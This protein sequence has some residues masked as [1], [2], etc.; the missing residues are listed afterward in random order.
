MAIFSHSR[1]SSFEQCK[2]KY[3]YHYIDKVETDV[4]RTIETYMGDLVHQTLEKL[5][6][7][8]KFQK[9]NDLS[10]LVDFYNGLWEKNWQ[11]GILIVKEQYTSENYRLM[12]QKMIEDYYAHYHP[13][14]Q[15]KTIG[16]ETEDYYELND[17]LSIHVR[18]DR[19]SSPKE[20]VYEIHDYKTNSNM[21]TQE[22]ADN[23]RQLAVYAMGVKKLFADAKRI[24]LIWHMLAFDK[25]VVSERTD[26]ELD[27]LK[28]EIIEEIGQIQKENSFDPTKSALC[29]Y[30]EYQSM[31]PLWK[32][33]FD[34]K[35]EEVNKEVLDG[36]T[37]VENYVKLK[38]YEKKVQ[39]KLSVVSDKIKLYADENNCRVLYGDNNAVTIWSKDAT[40]FPGKNDENRENFK[41]ALKAL[42]LYDRFVDVDTWVLEKEFPNFS[43]VEKSV[44]NNFGRKEKIFRLYLKKR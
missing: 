24:K 8:L 36:K 29:S 16:L 13:F 39:E 44:L 1:I 31:C 2:L 14:N 43:E 37:L 34:Q 38:E 17:E 18:I 42:N 22:E 30:C 19:L 9:L 15:G 20:G 25:E 3:K 21:K 11:E 41:D 40:K 10:E 28:N 27:I 4:V 35:K 5:Y 33:L 23:D 12:G 6:K 7:D 26:E 32:H